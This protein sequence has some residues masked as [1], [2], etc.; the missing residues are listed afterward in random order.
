MARERRDFASPDF[1]FLY[2]PKAR[3]MISLIPRCQ[4]FSQKIERRF[5]RKELCFADMLAMYHFHFLYLFALLGFAFSYFDAPA[6][7][8]RH[9]TVNFS[10]SRVA[11]AAKY[12]DASARLNA[13]WAAIL[14][15][16]RYLL[17]T[18]TRAPPPIDTASHF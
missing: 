13:R 10:F 5:A 15:S 7:P 9:S 6:L 3:L 1:D 2:Q 18:G 8:L 12:P 4:A 16:S 17:H 11:F 14:G